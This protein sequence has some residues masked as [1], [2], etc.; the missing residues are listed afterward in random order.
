MTAPFRRLLVLGL[1][2]ATAAA[3][4]VDA[5]ATRAGGD[6]QDS[7]TIYVQAMTQQGQPVQGIPANEFVVQEDNQIREIVEVKPATE[8]IYAIL[9][10]D[11]QIGVRDY[12]NDFRAGMTAFVN[13]ILTNSPQSQ[14]AL[15]EFAGAGMISH[16]FTSDKQALL[17][18]IP[19]M[20]PKAGITSL[21]VNE[22]VVEAAKT[23]ANVPSPRRLV[24]TINLEPTREDSTMAFQAIANEF[25]KAQAVIWAIAVQKPGNTDRNDGR[26]GLLEGLTKFS[27]GLR[28]SISTGPAVEGV[29]RAAAFNM[30]NQ[31]AVTFRRP[32][33][34][35][36]A[37]VTTVA[38]KRD[39]VRASTISWQ[40]EAGR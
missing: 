5:R 33:G 17:D 39:G 31:Y 6:A 35:K 30:L 14:V 9:M 3:L 26:N 1:A 18:Y 27:G 21:V 8:P 25:R 32:A 37:Q 24:V 29:L 34:A 16:K 36:P 22:G 28:A 13:D 11:T 38:V 15:G 4:S 23:I 2:A 20:A 10:A 40:P 12:V 19:K 7:R